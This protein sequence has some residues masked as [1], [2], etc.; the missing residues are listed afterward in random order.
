MIRTLFLSSA[1]GALALAVPALTSAYALQMQHDDMQHED[2]K[3]QD[4]KHQDMD[5]GEHDHEAHDH[6]DHDMEADEAASG[7]LVMLS[8]TAEIDAALA[9]GGEPAVAQVLGV[10]CDFCAK[11]MNKTFGKREEVAATYV[12]LDTKTLNL[13]FRP[14]Q[15]LDDE[16]IGELV[17][18][19]GYRIA[20][21][22]RG[23]AL[24]VESAQG[25]GA[26]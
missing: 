5:H 17:K 1:F 23:D 12:D 25:T 20:A 21:I 19:A 13:V 26:E 2:M 7:E 22:H 15:S 3:H 10:V 14:G 9:A 18:K 11:A 16:T 4:M 24:M 8:R 6:K